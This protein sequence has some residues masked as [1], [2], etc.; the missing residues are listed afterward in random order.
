MQQPPHSSPSRPSEEGKQ[1]EGRYFSQ[2]KTAFFSF[3]K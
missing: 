1:R 3:E 2:T